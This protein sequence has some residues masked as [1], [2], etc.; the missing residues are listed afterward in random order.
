MKLL[1]TLLSAVMVSGCAAQ[2][3]YYDNHYY[4]HG[5]YH[6][7]YYGH[8]IVIEHRDFHPEPRSFHHR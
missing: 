4:P 8:P 5:Y 6:R 7:D 3:A 1:W 2:P